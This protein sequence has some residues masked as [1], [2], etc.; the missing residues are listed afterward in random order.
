MT[1]TLSNITT[2]SALLPN[3][4]PLFQPVYMIYGNYLAEADGTV[5]PVTSDGDAAGNKR[6]YAAYWLVSP[7]AP[8]NFTTPL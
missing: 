1:V 6:T 4:S 7:D 5:A 2:M 3:G 8:T